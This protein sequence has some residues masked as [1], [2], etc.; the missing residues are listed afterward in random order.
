M[1]K[2]VK[3]IYENLETLKKFKTR[4]E[5]IKWGLDNFKAPA[6]FAC[7]KRE[8][9]RILNIDLDNDKLICDHCKDFFKKNKLLKI[10]D[11]RNICFNCASF[12]IYKKK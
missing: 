10:P 6:S 4:K 7:Y 11:G 2:T 3:I 1:S 9:K 8:I 12:L 5:F